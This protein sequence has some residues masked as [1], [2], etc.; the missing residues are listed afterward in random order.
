MTCY[1]YT[2][3]ASVRVGY[4]R[5]SVS[6]SEWADFQHYGNRYRRRSVAR[7]VEASDTDSALRTKL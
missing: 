6:L 2:L 5:Y 4:V 3:R 1:P 7:I